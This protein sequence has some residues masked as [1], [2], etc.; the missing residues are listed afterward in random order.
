MKY[1]SDMI[2]TTAMNKLWGFHLTFK[3]KVYIDEK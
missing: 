3:I 1:P 2:T